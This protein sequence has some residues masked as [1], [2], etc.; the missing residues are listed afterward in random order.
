M[1]GT[2]TR[3]GRNVII[4]SPTRLIL[5]ICLLWN[6]SCCSVPLC[7]K[8]PMEVPV[9][10]LGGSSPD[11]VQSGMRLL[12]LTKCAVKSLPKPGETWCFYSGLAQ[13]QT[14]GWALL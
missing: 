2:G 8:K 4:P 14:C 13:K 9:N 11:L 12:T 3:V 1:S 6:C 5:N 10:V 7:E